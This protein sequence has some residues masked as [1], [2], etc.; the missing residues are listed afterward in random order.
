MTIY[1]CSIECVEDANIEGIVS[2][3][4]N[5]IP[6]KFSF[7]LEHVSN[8]KEEI[9]DEYPTRVY[10]KRKAGFPR[11]VGLFKVPFNEFESVM[12]SFIKD[13]GMITFSVGGSGVTKSL[14]ERIEEK[15]KERE[16]R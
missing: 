2:P 14:R 4:Q 16:N 3:Q 11:S 13:S 15:M 8:W 1:T 9:N 6:L 7:Y 5:S 12:K 10:F